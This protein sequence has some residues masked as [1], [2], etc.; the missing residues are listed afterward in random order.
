MGG[1]GSSSGMSVNGKKYGTEY[2][3][4]AQSGNIKIVAYNGGASKTPMETMTK[5]RV[6]GTVND[7]GI[8]KS[9]TYYDK[10]NKR[11]K[12]ID[13]SHE[14]HGANPHAHLGYY[15]NEKG[16]R[17]KLTPSEKKT[18]ERVKKLWKHAR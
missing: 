12:Q 7:K 8:L 11:F 2:K 9:I 1:R 16:D 17:L 4:L 15:H 14:H 3:T 13:L 10:G 5:G 18:V 6:Y